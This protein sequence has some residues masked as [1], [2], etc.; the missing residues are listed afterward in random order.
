MQNETCKKVK[1]QSLHRPSAKSWNGYK[2][3]PLLTI[4]GNWLAQVGFNIDSIV[5]ITTSENQL[6]IKKE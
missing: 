3:V 2:R 4:S 6:I 5:E 1:I